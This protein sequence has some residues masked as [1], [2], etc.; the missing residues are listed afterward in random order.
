MI[1]S[2]SIAVANFLA[3]APVDYSS[4]H[5]LRRSMAPPPPPPP[6][7]PWQGYEPVSDADAAAFREKGF[8][9]EPRPLFPPGAIEAAVRG[10]NMVVRGEEDTS[11]HERFSARVRSRQVVSSARSS[12]ARVLRRPTSSAST[13]PAHR[14]PQG[15]RLGGDGCRDGPRFLVYGC[16][17]ERDATIDT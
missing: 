15:G 10:M 4:S 16:E 5:H 6:R 14:L 12:S 13:G 17:E 8:H 11:Q 3:S 1:F 2:R 7:L 9:L